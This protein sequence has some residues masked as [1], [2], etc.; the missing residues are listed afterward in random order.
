MQTLCFMSD[1]ASADLAAWV[2][3]VGTI[4]AVIGAAWIAIWQSRVQHK[5]AMALMKAEQRTTRLERGKAMLTQATNCKLLV[6][7]AAGRFRQALGDPAMQDE[8]MG[9]EFATIKGLGRTLAA[10][11]LHDLP[12]GFVTPVML[13]NIYVGQFIETVQLILDRRARIEDRTTLNSEEFA[14]LLDKSFGGIETQLDE[15]SQV[16]LNALNQIQAEV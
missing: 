11:S 1:I 12:V 4:L 2:Q 5:S 13:L 8:A 10:I 7:N 9:I 3:A 15:I 16:M 6:T 14:K